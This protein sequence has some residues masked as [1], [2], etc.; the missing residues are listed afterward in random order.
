MQQVK[1]ISAFICVE[2]NGDEAIPAVYLNGAWM[3]LAG[4]DAERIASLKPHAT[5]IL[6]HNP[7]LARLELRRY[8]M[9]ELIE[10]FT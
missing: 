4:A 6:E 8:V 5:E 9:D 3:P 1:T 10:T 7:D 2:K